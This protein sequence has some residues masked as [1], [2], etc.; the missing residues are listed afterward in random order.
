[1]DTTHVNPIKH[2]YSNYISY[3][4][5]SVLMQLTGKEKATLC[6]VFQTVDQSKTYSATAKLHRAVQRS[7][8]YC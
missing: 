7:T 3:R 2:T 1:M 4:H 8:E 6:G 5:L